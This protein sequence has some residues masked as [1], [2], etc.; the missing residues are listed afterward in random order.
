MNAGEFFMPIS[1]KI[2]TFLIFA[3]IN[4][5][6]VTEN[7]INAL[8]FFNILQ[9]GSPGI[10]YDI[11]APS[12][13]DICGDIVLIIVFAVAYFFTPAAAIKRT[14]KNLPGNLKDGLDERYQE[15]IKQLKNYLKKKGV[16]PLLS[17]I[18]KGSIRQIKRY[19]C[20]TKDIFFVAST[21]FGL[22]LFSKYILSVGLEVLHIENENINFILNSL[23]DVIKLCSSLVFVY[24][25]CSYLS[26]SR[27]INFIIYGFFFIRNFFSTN[28]IGL[29]TECDVHV[30]VPFL[31]VLTPIIIIY[32]LF[33]FFANYRTT[34][35]FKIV[36]IKKNQVYN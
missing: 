30:V 6:F 1:V 32:T 12:L 27:V 7:V 24:I 15:V 3:G 23:N 16:A 22:Y 14:V 10:K 36:G 8:V 26:T 31:D 21:G 9:S 11:H 13:P 4:L 2:C 25:Y 20:W 29:F 19:T 33:Y 5:R 28:A 35:L 34:L 18:H 17:H